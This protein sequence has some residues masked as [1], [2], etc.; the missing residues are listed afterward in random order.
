MAVS[1]GERGLLLSRVRDESQTTIAAYKALYES[2]IAVGVR[3]ALLAEKAMADME[4]RVK[5]LNYPI[6][7]YWIIPAWFQKYLSSNISK[8]IQF[9]RYFAIYPAE[10]GV[11]L[12]F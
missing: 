5:S 6:M 10:G 1:C 9:K 8:K 12:F 11:C 3:K 2:S 7:S 4:K